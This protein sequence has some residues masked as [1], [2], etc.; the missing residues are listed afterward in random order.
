MTSLSMGLEM[1]FNKGKWKEKNCPQIKSQILGALIG[2]VR[3]FLV[4]PGIMMRAVRL[5]G[6]WWAPAIEEI[7][8]FRVA[9]GPTALIGGNIAGGRMPVRGRGHFGYHGCAG[10]RQRGGRSARAQGSGRT[11]E[12]WSAGALSRGFRMGGKV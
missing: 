3:L 12:R 8:L 1:F 6:N 7:V 2:S 9:F 4:C 11:G 5:A 10:T